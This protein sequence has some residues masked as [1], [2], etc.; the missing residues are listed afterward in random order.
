M[1]TDT[2]QGNEPLP[3]AAAVDSAPAGSAPPV[4]SARSKAD[5]DTVGLRKEIRSW[6]RLAGLRT[7]AGKSEP[8][9]GQV[10]KTDGDSLAMAELAFRDALDDLDAKLDKGQKNLLRRLYRAE[11][12]KDPGQWLA[13]AVGSL[14]IGARVPVAAPPA[15]APAPAAPAPV[16][17][18]GP[19]AAGSVTSLPANPRDMSPAQ[20][21]A[22]RASGD[23]ARIKAEWD[24]KNDRNRNPWAKPPTK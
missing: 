4:D 3:A 23:F 16:T 14:G 20:L 9:P 12:P 8:A 1:S 10:A 22:A 11:Q 2:T 17:N 18:T 6:L 13:D 19:A 5:P 21:Q 15:P 24:A 7:Q